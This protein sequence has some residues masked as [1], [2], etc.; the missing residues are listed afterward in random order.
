MNDNIGGFKNNP[1]LKTLKAPEGWPGTP[2]DQ[3]GRFLNLN[4]PFVANLVDVFR[5]K[6]ESSPFKKEKKAENWNPL[7]FKDDSW[8]KSDEDMIVWLGHSTFFMRLG[9]IQILTDPVFGNILSVKRRS[10]FP[11]DAHLLADLDYILLSHDHRDHLDEKSLKL[12]SGQNPDVTY[13][14][15]VGMKKIVHSFTRSNKIE[16]AG[17]YQQYYTG[18]SPIKITFIPSRHWSTRSL[19]NINRRLWGGFVIETANKRILFGG[20]SGYDTHYNQLA[21]VFGSFEYAILGIGAYE[22]AWF[23]SANHQSPADALQGFTELNA[24]RFIPMH[25][26]TFDLSDEPLS[27]PLK[28]LHAAAFIRNLEDRLDILSIGK[29]LVLRVV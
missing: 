11:V 8:L 17:W 16:E 20:D 9:G 28:D 10:Q 21:A 25:Y 15:G 23:M 4:H 26:S 24:A 14:T 19:F 29:P 22:P 5:W 6:F 18:N 3:K 2:V 13:L 27:Q 1:K 12:L 7:I